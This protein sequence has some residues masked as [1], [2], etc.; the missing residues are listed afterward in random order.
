MDARAELPS[1]EFDEDGFVRE[2]GVDDYIGQVMERFAESPECGAVFEAQG[3]PYWSAIFVDYGLRYLGRE[4]EG[5]LAPDL[6]EILLEVFPA[7]VTC[8]P[9]EAGAI[10]AE[11]RA[12]WRFLQR[13]HRLRQAGSC[14]ETLDDPLFVEVLEAELSDPANYG[15]AKSFVMA[16]WKAGFDMASRDGIAAFQ[17][18]WNDGL[19]PDTRRRDE[20]ERLAAPARREARKA[21]NRRRKAQKVSRRKNRRKR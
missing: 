11:L 3:G 1:V 6:Q 9:G 14:L 8:D 12:F 19:L 5:M 13:E 18:A 15:M 4:L 21:K 7:K 17:G 20:G 10:V 2:E 16:G